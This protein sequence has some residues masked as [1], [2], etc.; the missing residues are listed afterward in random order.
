MS[1]SPLRFLVLMVVGWVHR[2]QADVIGYL[3]EENRVLREHLGPRRLPFTDA[4]RRRL[5]T[6]G[7]LVGRKALREVA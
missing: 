5:A 7:K 4:Q 6:K 3:V 1:P 2:H